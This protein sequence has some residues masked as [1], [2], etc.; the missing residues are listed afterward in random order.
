MQEQEGFKMP[1]MEENFTERPVRVEKEE[2][3]EAWHRDRE[4][5]A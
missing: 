5:A 2:F 1:K 4:D 3:I